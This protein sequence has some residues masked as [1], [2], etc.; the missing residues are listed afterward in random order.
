MIKSLGVLVGAF[1]LSATCAVAVPVQPISYDMPNGSSGSYQYW[2]ESYNGSGNPFV[3]GSTLSG[4]TGDLTNGVI[5]TQNWFIVEQPSGAGPYVGWQSDPTITFHFAQ[6]WDF[7]SLTLYV[8]DSNGHGGV[9]T[10]A[11]VTVN[12]AYT[13]IADP[14]SSAPFGVT[15]DLTGLADTDTL[16]VSLTRRSSWVFLS[17]VTFDA[18]PVPLPAGVVLMGTGLAGLGLLRARRG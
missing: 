1:G 3:N 11:G 12:G 6:A 4:G 15:I 13:A 2:D 16:V 10:P 18:T 5:A 14:A 9:S 7:N 17:E 8:D